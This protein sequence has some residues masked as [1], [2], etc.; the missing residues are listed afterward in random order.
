MYN[1]RMDLMDTKKGYYRNIQ[2]RIGMVLMCYTIVLR[3]SNVD[4][5]LTDVNVIDWLDNTME[6]DGYTIQYKDRLQLMQH[7]TQWYHESIVS[8]TIHNWDN[9]A[10]QW[11][12]HL[13]SIESNVSFDFSIGCYWLIIFMIPNHW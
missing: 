7:Q 9:N 13:N 1:Q 10:F 11:L 3:S 2:S 5:T 8:V 6:E 4:S 12:L